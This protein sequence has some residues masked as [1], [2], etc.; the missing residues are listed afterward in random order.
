MRRQP[1]PEITDILK[2]RNKKVKLAAENLYKK[3]SEEKK[4]V[5]VV[6]FLTLSFFFGHS[7]KIGLS[8]SC[9]AYRLGDLGDAR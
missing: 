4:R 3:L 1:F 8:D 6:D 9:K 2:K 5:M 7:L